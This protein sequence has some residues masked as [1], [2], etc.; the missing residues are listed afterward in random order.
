MPDSMATPQT[1]CG[2][3]DE[4]MV[5]QAA[6]EDPHGFA[7]LYDRYRDRVYTYL[8]A[9]TTSGEDAAD[10]TQQVFLRA[11]D[12]LPQYRGGREAFAPWL[13]RI[14]R[15]AATDFYRRQRATVPWDRVPTALQPVATLDL[16]AGALQG[17]AVTQLRAL[18][19]TLDDDTRELLALRFGAALTVGEVAALIGKS[20]AAT[21]KRLARTLHALA[22]R[23]E[24]G[25]P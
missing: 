22:A 24:G 9:R 1:D 12:A 16:E 23:L 13:F 8:R 15:N 2:V 11:F 18:L 20:E 25:Q 4:T 19:A 7:V 3:S 5:V 14:A 10:L 6:Q 17:E 21:R